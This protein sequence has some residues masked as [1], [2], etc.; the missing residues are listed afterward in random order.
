[1]KFPPKEQDYKTFEMNNKSISL[2]ILYNPHNTEE[3][4]HAYTSKFN[5]TRERQLIL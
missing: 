4:S 5:K 1:M 3:I 2:N